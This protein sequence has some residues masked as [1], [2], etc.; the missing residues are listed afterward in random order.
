[1]RKHPVFAWLQEGGLWWLTGMAFIFVPL[2]PDVEP[3][4][5][6]HWWGYLVS[7]AIGMSC[8]MQADAVGNHYRYQKLLERGLV[9]P[10]RY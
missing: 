4:I 8:G 2:H 7:V 1:M 6:D 10:E 3:L 9:D 5:S